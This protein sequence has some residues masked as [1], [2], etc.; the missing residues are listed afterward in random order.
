MVVRLLVLSV[1]LRV[2]FLN[3]TCIGEQDPAQINGCRRRVD[4]ATKASLY[5][6]RNPSAVVEMRMRQHTPVDFGRRDR[7]VLPVPL[8]PLFLP[9]KQAAVDEDLQ[10]TLASAVAWNADEMF[11]ASDGP[12]GAEKLDVCQ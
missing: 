3:V 4:R 12:G 2:F 1:K 5:Q 8:A 10:T 11:R 6:A 9:L 7:K